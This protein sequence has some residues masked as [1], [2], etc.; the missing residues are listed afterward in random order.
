VVRLHL[1][2]DTVFD[3]HSF[4]FLNSVLANF[5]SQV[6]DVGSIPIARSINPVD[7][8][9]FTGFHSLNWPIKCAILDAVGRGF[10]SLIPVGR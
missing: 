3:G 6:S 10:A 1:Y 2:S 7:A 9:G 5:A 4:C 8:V